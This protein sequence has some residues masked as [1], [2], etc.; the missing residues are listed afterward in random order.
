MDEKGVAAASSNVRNGGKPQARA[1]RRVR[2]VA[3]ED[4]LAA[5]FNDPNYDLRSGTPPPPYQSVESLSLGPYQVTP[6]SDPLRSAEE[7]IVS[8]T[9]PPSS[10]DGQGDNSEADGSPVDSRMADSSALD[11]GQA[12]STS[13][14]SPR[15]FRTEEYE[16]AG[17]VSLTL[18]ECT[19]AHITPEN[20]RMLKFEPQ[21]PM[22]IVLGCQSIHSECDSCAV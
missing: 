16:E 21:S 14:A 13:N 1:R 5:H 8:D 18:D 11:S 9:Q 4:V 22:S 15:K 17:Y 6:V 7:G 19:H 3:A 10:S 20:L 12:D 2:R